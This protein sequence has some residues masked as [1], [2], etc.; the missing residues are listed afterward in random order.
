M[1]EF[2]IPDM[3]LACDKSR[4]YSGSQVAA[5]ANHMHPLP[6]PDLHL[7]LVMLPVLGR[8]PFTVVSVVTRA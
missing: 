4:M 3:G 2:L 1:S 7:C 5:A 8:K 6:E